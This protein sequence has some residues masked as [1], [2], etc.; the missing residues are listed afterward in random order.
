M[1]EVDSTQIFQDEKPQV[2]EVTLEEFDELVLDKKALDEML[3][4]YS[5]NRIFSKYTHDEFERLSGLL[6]SSNPKV[7][8]DRDI[9][10]EKIASIGHLEKFI[11]VLV[12]NLQG[13]DNPEQRLHLLAE[14]EKYRE[15]E[16]KEGASNE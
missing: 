6:K 14:I 10:V 9:I 4:S 8:Q 5:F 15:D 1:Q 12:T 3:E 13:I 2:I 16:E 7:I 11:S